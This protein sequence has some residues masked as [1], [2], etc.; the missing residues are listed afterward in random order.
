[1]QIDLKTV[2]IEPKRKAFDHLVRRF[3]DKVAS[4]YQEGSY[5]LQ[6]MENLH[7]RPTWDPEQELYDPNLSRVRMADWR[8]EEHTSELQSH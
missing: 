5:D 8:S 1:M 2:N 4:R 7:Y 6:A 3:G